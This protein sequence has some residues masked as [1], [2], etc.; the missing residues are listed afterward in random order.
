MGLGRDEVPIPPSPKFHH[1]LNLLDCDR[2]DK[3]SDFTDKLST[4]RNIGKGP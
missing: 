2:P 4:P 3:S 1:T